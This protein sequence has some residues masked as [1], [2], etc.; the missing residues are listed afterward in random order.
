MPDEI[1]TKGAD[2][3]L[4]LG[5]IGV[6]IL[7]ILFAVVYLERKATRR[8]EKLDAE[9]AERDKENLESRMR[10]VE[11]MNANTVATRE[12]QQEFRSFAAKVAK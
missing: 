6:F 5:A 9:R 4:D 3:L 7:V 11:A 10:M 12:L 1:I 2:S 8:E